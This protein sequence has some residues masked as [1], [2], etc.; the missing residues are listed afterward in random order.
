MA[1]LTRREAQSAATPLSRWSLVGVAPLLLL[2]AAFMWEA[3]RLWARLEVTNSHQP[4]HITMAE[5]LRSQGGGSEM[6]LMSR[7]PA[8]AFHADAAWAPTPNAS[9]EETLAY[10]R[11][12]GATHIIIDEYEAKLRPQLA[13][14]LDGTTTDAALERVATVDEGRGPVVAYR[15]K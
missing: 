6:R 5:Q 15:I 12:R 4:A 10:A 9:W 13:F 11:R 2:L 3:P 1:A 14:L 8:I 7:Y